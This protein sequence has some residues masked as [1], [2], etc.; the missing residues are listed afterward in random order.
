MSY[1]CFEPE[2]S[3]SGR[4]LC[5]QLWYSMFYMNRYKQSTRYR[6]VFDVL[7]PTR[8]LIPMHVKYTIPH[9]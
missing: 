1:V 9:L 7:L 6:S 5:I 3:T 2:V 4:R 8:L